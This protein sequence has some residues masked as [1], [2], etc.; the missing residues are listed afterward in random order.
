MLDFFDWIL[1]LFTSLIK[2][3]IVV[4][5]GLFFANMIIFNYSLGISLADI[6]GIP[7]DLALS[8]T[9]LGFV[10]NITVVSTVFEIIIIGVI[11]NK[12][13]GIKKVNLIFNSF[14]EFMRIF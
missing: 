10:N 13:N 14:Y 3:I 7:Y 5:I 6:T 8:M 2:T 12:L 11:I 1:I 9:S 4:C